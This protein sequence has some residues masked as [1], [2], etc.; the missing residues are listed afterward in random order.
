MWR[1]QG[2]VAKE[3]ANPHGMPPDQKLYT[4]NRKVPAARE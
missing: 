2:P 3:L 4:V 1:R